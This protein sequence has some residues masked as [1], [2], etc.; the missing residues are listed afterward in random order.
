[1][2][3]LTDKK[4]QVVREVTVYTDGACT[5]NP[6]PGGWG[7]LLIFGKVEKT[8]VGGESETTNNRMELMAAIR[9]L[10]ALKQ[11]CK[12][13][14]YTDSRYVMDGMTRWMAGWKKNRWQT[15]ARKPVKNQD[16]WQR[17]D[18]AAAIHEVH[19]NWVRGHSGDVMNERV[20][21]LARD[22][23]PEVSQ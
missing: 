6:G 9:S 22:A 19:W 11:S 18:A 3:L 7:A 13:D 2:S 15:S 23:I 12:V 10:E 16:L 21:Q 20:D 5:G 1:M 8:L 14:L 17:L 4:E